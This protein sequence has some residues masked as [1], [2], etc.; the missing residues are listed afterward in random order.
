MFYIDFTIRN[1]YG[2]LLGRRLPDSDALV[3][4]KGSV[5]EF[6]WELA[7]D[8]KGSMWE[9]GWELALAFDAGFP[10]FSSS[11]NRWF[12]ITCSFSLDTRVCRPD[13]ALF[14]NNSSYC[15]E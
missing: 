13:P 6:G 12:L 7:F 8:L 15:H 3:S 10:E 4:L 2:R 5:W 11:L 9:F 14:N 1:H